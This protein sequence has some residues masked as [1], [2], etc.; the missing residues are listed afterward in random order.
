MFGASGTEGGFARFIYVERVDEAITIRWK[1]VALSAAIIAAIAALFAAALADAGAYN[2]GPFDISY[3][4]DGGINDEDNPTSYMRDTD[5]GIRPASK[6]GMVFAGWYLDSDCRERFPGSTVGMTGDLVLYAGWADD[7]SG[8]G[9]SYSLSGYAEDGTRTWKF[10]GTAEISRMY[11]SPFRLA[12]Y[13]QTDYSA[14]VTEYMFGNITDSLTVSDTSSSWSSALMT[15]VT[16]IGSETLSTAS[17]DR[18]CSVYSAMSK[19]GI[20]LRL[21]VCDDDSIVYRVTGDSGTV[22][23]S[24]EFADRHDVPV[25]EHVSV[26]IRGDRGIIAQGDGADSPGSI[27]T[28]SAAGDGFS[29]WYDSDGNL[30]SDSP[31]FGYEIGMRDAELFARGASGPIAAVA[32]D[33]CILSTGFTLSDAVWNL[34]GDDGQIATLEGSEPAFAFPAPGTYTAEVG[35]TYDGT[36]LLWSICIICDGDVSRTYTWT[37]GGVTYSCSVTMTYSH[38]LGLKGSSYDDRGSVGDGSVVFATPDDP[39]ISALAAELGSIAEGMDDAETANLVLTFVQSM[40][41]DGSDLWKYPVEVL[42]ESCGNDRS[43]S[44]L[45]ASLMSSLGFRSSI[46]LFPGHT[47]AGVEVDGA[48]GTFYSNGG[49][50]YRYCECSP[51]A[52]LAIG[53]KPEGVA[54]RVSK[55]LEVQHRFPAGTACFSPD[56]PE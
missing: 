56:D 29:G 45:Y 4:L 15:S 44:A 52:D 11:Y 27:L 26:T 1:D 53:E 43:C 47:A 3:D 13:M 2:A 18:M 50:K 38:Y 55:V 35:G 12:Y 37:Y 49:I 54:N 5:A 28:L 17:G 30:L 25:V 16:Y 31:S 19:D 46:L 41:D 21:W 6:E 48:T 8:T 9:T 14:D 40:A 10:D 32:G 36:E 39:V 51:S 23:F 20:S 7:E 24:M 34:S 42:F 22:H 33:E